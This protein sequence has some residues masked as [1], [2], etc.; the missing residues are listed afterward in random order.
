MDNATYKAKPNHITLTY[1]MPPIKANLI[2][3]LTN[4]NQLG[5]IM[6]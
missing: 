2:D 4:P 3:Y 6:S 5:S 1:I